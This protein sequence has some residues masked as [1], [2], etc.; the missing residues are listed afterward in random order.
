MNISSNQW[1]A[2]PMTRE[3]AHALRA[4]AKERRVLREDADALLADAGILKLEG[5]VKIRCPYPQYQ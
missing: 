5:D 2:T 3:V 1:Y 4:D